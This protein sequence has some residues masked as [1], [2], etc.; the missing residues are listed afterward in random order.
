MNNWL[1]FRLSTRPEL[2][3]VSWK[4]HK[5]DDSYCSDQ[6][7]RDDDNYSKNIINNS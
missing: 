2:V 1:Y 7:D 6:L 3:F 4:T 5:I